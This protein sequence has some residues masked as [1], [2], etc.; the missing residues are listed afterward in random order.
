MRL[1]RLEA[2]GF[3]SFCDKAVVNFVQKGI[4]IVVGPN[5]CGKSNIVDAI[6]WT[7]GEQSAKHLRGS[8]MEDVIFN[9]SSVRQPVSMAQVTLV[10]S[11]SEHDTIPKYS[12]F[13]E[14]SV[15]RRLYRSGESQY[16]INKTAC[17]LTDI[18][19]LFMDTGIG[20]R[21]YSIIE[22]GKIDQIIT[23]RAEDRRLIIDEAAGIV[24]FKT[25]RKEAERKFATTKQNL[26]R[27]EDILAELTHQEETLKDQVERADEFLAAKSKLE[28]LQHC[29]A[30]TRWYKLKEQAE[31]I[32]KD[33]NENIQQ[34]NDLKLA[35][36]SLETR[37]SALNLEITEK[38]AKYEEFLSQIQKQKEEIIKLESKLETNKI[39]LDN[40]DEW[41]KKNKD[42]IDLLD[43]QIKTIEYQIQT[44]LSD[45]ESLEKEIAAKTEILEQFQEREKVSENELSDQ[46]EKLEKNQ[47]HEIEVV[48]QL[49]GNQNQ[50]VQ[51]QERLTEAGEKQEQLDSQL[52]KL[53]EEQKTVTFSLEE[54]SKKLEA[55]KEKKSSCRDIIDTHKEK[56]D[57]QH[58][59][60]S[61]LNENI[62]TISQEHNQ[63]ENRHRSLEEFILNRE[64]FDTATRK[65]LELMDSNKSLS[66]ELGFK[67]TLAELVSPPAEIL[68]Q[69]KAFLNR[70]FNLL[71]FN[72]IDNLESIV[73]LVK[74]E[75]IEQLQLY[76]LDLM[77]EES[78]NKKNSL[79]KLIPC[80]SELS[81]NL[82]FVDLFESI[83]T[84]V[85]SLSKS[86]LLEA[87]GLVD[88]EASMMTKARIF[89]IG[90][91]G[92]SNMA[93]TFLRRR[94]EMAELEKKLEVIGQELEKLEESHDRETEVLEELDRM[95]ENAKKELVDLD[96]ELVGLEKELDARSIE[97]QRLEN[98]HKRILNESQQ[99]DESKAKYKVTIDNLTN[100]TQELEKKHEEIKDSNNRLRS[101][102][103]HVETSK[104][105]TQDELQHLRVTLAGLNEK[106]DNN[107]K[108][109]SMMQADTE[110]RQKQRDDIVRRMEETED[111]RQ[112]AE[113]SIK[114]TQVELP[115]LLEEL[116]KKEKKIK[117]LSDKIETDRSQLTELKELVQAEQKKINELN[118]KNHKLEIK[119]AQLAQE[120]KNIEDNLFTEDSIR[121]DEIIETFDVKS[122]DIDKETRAIAKLKQSIGG[123]DNVNL[124]A[125]SEYE[126]LKERLDFLSAQSTDLKLSIE[127][128]EDSINK[129]NQESRRRF[130]DTFKQVNERFNELFP[131]LFG[132][133]EAYL[134]LTDETDILE[135][136]VEI[137]AQPPGKKLQ[138]MTL[139]SGG[140]KALT[141]IA[142]VFAVFMIKPSPF[143]LLDEVD[144]P[145]DEANNVR[146][147]KHVQALTDN[148]Q[149]IIITH[150]KKTM[151]IGDAL[152]G[153]T[154]EEP[155]I[156]K[157]VSVD[158]ATFSED[159]LQKAI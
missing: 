54:T 73:S 59:L 38:A 103:E 30:A 10:F 34:Q 9:G 29:L 121:P 155:G 131:Q 11:N 115:K 98:D 55:A 70:Y 130:R 53:E 64:E 87:E 12:E 80:K 69:I 134:K 88:P 43:K 101:L 90:Q 119:F 74:N 118:E 19:E 8:S 18:R 137:I 158:F 150:N 151:E 4:S 52:I 102:I 143:C 79:S 127:A 72:S 91:P 156:S 144:A 67:G 140:E 47:Q 114:E 109:V 113:S 57:A 62:K 78:E 116:E 149:F 105:E 48:K 129:I 145:L 92:K 147:N 89:L 25:K 65:F 68:P 28:R 41:E 33:K 22:Q 51:M 96:L 50:L 13:S 110:Q 85:Y 122:F 14:I 66:N 84:P 21:G 71:I 1:L 133:G 27:V 112:L 82:P 5:G 100:S 46:R 39:T 142:L 86:Q 16:L 117:D 40:L 17:R 106:Q 135:S 44:Y 23:S 136:G 125:K 152:F 6:R 138:N 37:E 99:I 32:E 49:T 123:M 56:K 75:N 141:A 104:E 159:S 124:A 31:K 157:I 107:R 3:K 128:L 76:F 97:K 81:I 139:L 120:A 93:E 24:K 126:T 20:G 7:L 83:E 26:V 15:T 2:S 94:S 36:T 42:E 45:N 153:V 60:I 146:F 148:S 111:K 63:A 61:E 35:S 95:L 108:S 154:M 77:P 132:G 58:Q